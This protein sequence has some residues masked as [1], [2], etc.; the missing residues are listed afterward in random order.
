MGLR[1]SVA[2]IN[3]TGELLHEGRFAEVLCLLESE[4]T[5]DLTASPTLALH[6]AIAHGRTGRHADSVHWAERALEGALEVGDRALHARA[7]NVR[8]AIALDT[9]CLREAEGH[10]QTA[11]SEA[12]GIGD[13]AIVGKCCNNLGI[14]ANMRGRHDEAVACYTMARVAY[15]RAGLERGLA[16]TQNNLWIT[17][18]DQGDLPAALEAANRAVDLAERTGDRAL[19]ALAIG[20]RAEIHVLAGDPQLALREIEFALRLRREVGDVTGEAD[21]LRVLG[22]A[23]AAL[24]Q[25]GAAEQSLRSALERAQRFGRPLL[26]AETGRAL[27]GLLAE[28]GRI[29]EARDVAH[30]ARVRFCRLGAVAEVKRLDRLMETR[31]D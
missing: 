30:A 4:R 13:H 28:Q 6:C 24:G 12:D 20:G 26:A 9:G 10:F 8:G 16:E 14:I 15:E 5:G 11:L 22:M 17:H 3:R 18:R 29:T 23:E 31:L 21:D 1:D 25:H 27:F 7:L 19:L 2:E